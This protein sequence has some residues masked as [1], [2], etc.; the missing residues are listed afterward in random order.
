[1]YLIVIV[2]VNNIIFI[3]ILGLLDSPRHGDEIGMLDDL[4]VCSSVML[5]RSG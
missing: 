2:V 3:I 4:L 1:M 5:L